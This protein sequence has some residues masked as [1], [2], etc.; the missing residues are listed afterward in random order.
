MSLPAFSYKCK[1]F[2]NLTTSSTNNTLQTIPTNTIDTSKTKST[3]ITITE[4]S[5]SSLNNSTYERKLNTI[6]K[7]L[8]THTTQIT[9]YKLLIN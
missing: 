4:N 1:T 7:I 5:K 2:R 6:L 3:L 9:N 8:E